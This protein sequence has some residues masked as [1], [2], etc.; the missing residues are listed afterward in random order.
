MLDAQPPVSAAIRNAL[1]R[2]RLSEQIELPDLYSKMS[3][4]LNFAV[5]G[6]VRS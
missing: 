4:S 3:D 5:H 6:P 2:G 1:D